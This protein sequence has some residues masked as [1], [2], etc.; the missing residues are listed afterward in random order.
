MP[1]RMQT[2]PPPPPA[3]GFIPRP[4]A[5]FILAATLA[6]LAACSSQ[7][8]T[9]TGQLHLAPGRFY[10]PPGPPG[11]PWGPYIRQA[12]ARFGVPEA[13][14][15]AVMRQES[16]GEA[17]AL[18]SAGAMGLMQVMPSTYE[19]LREQYNLGDDPFEPHDN[20]F[21]GTAYIRQMYGRYGAPGFL[22]AYNAGPARVDEY[23]ATGD[24]LPD[25]TVGYLTAIAPRLGNST[26]MTG[27]L[28]VYAGNG[29][30]VAQPPVMM[31]S[32]SGA[33]DPDAAY[34][35]TRPC[36][37]APTPP[38]VPVAAEAPVVMAS[39]NSVCD[40]DAAYDPTRPC[41]S[42]PQRA[43]S[44]VPLTR[45]IPFATQSALYHPQ[46]A[47]VEPASIPAAA[48]F[49]PPAAAAAT[50]AWAIQ[51]GAFSSPESARRAANTARHAL[52]D[53]LGPARLQVTP[54]EPFGNSV[55]FRAQLANLS[56]DSA[57][58]AC[59]RLSAAAMPC[60]IVRPSSG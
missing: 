34:D 57:A 15:R 40:P 54:T 8:V 46:A 4:F 36:T 33:C 18:S 32:A 16:A 35:P 5:A 23:L 3:A 7:S 39:A 21:A 44:A 59:A 52:P 28:S 49:T 20:I 14:I 17:Q 41:A 30:Y 12:S 47:P 51:V 9:R 2:R 29:A 37:P 60:L 26:P 11:D 42:P 13:W 56:A 48:P 55:L 38:Q 25:E 45:P 31:A 43:I 50:G 58:A 1:V 19:T 27:P 22:A 6:V 10:P 53:V 24:P